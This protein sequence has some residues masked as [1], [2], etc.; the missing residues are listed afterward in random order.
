MEGS[1]ATTRKPRHPFSWCPG[2][3]ILGCGFARRR[4][5][6]VVRGVSC[7]GGEVVAGERE[8][9]RTER[10]AP[11]S[12]GCEDRPNHPE[13]GEEDHEAATRRRWH[14][15]RLG[16]WT[17]GAFVARPTMR[18]MT[19]KHRRRRHP[20]VPGF[21]LAAPARAERCLR[22]AVKQ[23]VSFFSCRAR[24]PGGGGGR[25]AHQVGENDR[26]GPTDANASK[27]AQD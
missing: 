15:L 26:I 4:V 13:G 10:R 1:E 18:I 6:C 7:G 2:I 20:A 21:R 12:R 24:G 27:Q 17:R 25:A 8:S 14:H 9:W 3:R 19:K 22:R 23:P 11:A 5:R 16:G